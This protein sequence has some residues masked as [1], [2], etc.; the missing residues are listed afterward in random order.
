MK[1]PLRLPALLLIFVF[2]VILSSCTANSGENVAMGTFYSISV[3]GSGSKKLIYE[4]EKLITEIEEQCSV[5]VIGSDLYNI[6]AAQA[7]VQISIGTHTLTLIK[8]SLSLYYSTNGAFN[9]AVFPLVE[10]WKFSAFNFTGF[11]NALPSDADITDML[12]VCK[13]ENF[14]LDEA[15][16]TIAKTDGRA[17]LDFG[18]IA[19]GYIVDLITGLFAEKDEFLIDVGG[20]LSTKGKIK[21]IGVTNPRDISNIKG[22]IELNNSAVATSGDYQRCYFYEGKRYHHILSPDGHPSSGAI[23]VSIVGE[24]A[25]LCDA[26]ST[27]VMILEKDE[28]EALLT[29]EG[30]SAVIFYE[31]SFAIIGDICFYER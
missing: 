15:G 24:S 18:G 21:K 30:Y 22:I 17:K 6:N 16:M 31:N 1:K 20:N 12:P 29:K 19:K 5:S 4:A 23:S 27:A 10:L 7:N 26:Y 2:L 9:P 14:V 28:A 11:V 25:M 13:M 3:K 8:A